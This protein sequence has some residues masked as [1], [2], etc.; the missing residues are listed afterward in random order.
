MTLTD[1]IITLD[2]LYAQG[3]INENTHIYA[4]HIA[5]LYKTHDELCAYFANLD[6]PYTVTV[7]YD[8]LSVENE[9]GMFEEETK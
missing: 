3:T 4:T 6:K 2:R 5:G 8:G 9:T 1:K 7:A